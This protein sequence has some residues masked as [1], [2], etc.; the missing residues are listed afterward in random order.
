LACG[1]PAPA[2]MV[3]AMIVVTGES[4]SMIG[5]EATLGIAKGTAS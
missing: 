5:F 2:G 3:K 4:D 1:Q